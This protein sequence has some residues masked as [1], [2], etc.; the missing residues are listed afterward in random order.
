MHEKSAEYYRKNA[1]PIANIKQVPTGGRVCKMN[2][3][4]CSSCGYKE[5][6]VIDFLPVRGQEAVQSKEVYPY[7][8]FEMFFN[9]LEYARQ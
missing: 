2:V 7:S 9:D 4:R 3:F 8:E 6:E 5:V 1:K